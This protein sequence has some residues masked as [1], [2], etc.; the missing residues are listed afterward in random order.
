MLLKPVLVALGLITVVQATRFVKSAQGFDI[1]TPVPVYNPG[2]KDSMMLPL[3]Q[4]RNQV[5]KFPIAD[6]CDGIINQFNH[7]KPINDPA[8]KVPNQA[9]VPSAVYRMMGI[10]KGR[11]M[12]AAT[13]YGHTFFPLDPGPAYSYF[14]TDDAKRQ[15][16]LV[17]RTRDTSFLYFGKSPT[18]Y[19]QAWY[20]PMGTFS[21]ISYLDQNDCF[22]EQSLSYPVLLRM[23]QFF[24]R[25]FRSFMDTVAR[26]L[27]RSLL[28]RSGQGQSLHPVLQRRR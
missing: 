23:S 7:G 27:T 4:K 12:F 20:A 8:I 11:D 17:V 2:A 9:K 15:G 24:G 25:Y 1:I 28:T 21:D 6:F 18:F 22:Y 3:P 13:F 19:I 16:T 26:P 5:S 14:C 10:K